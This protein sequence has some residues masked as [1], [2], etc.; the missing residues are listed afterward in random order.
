MPY[1]NSFHVRFDLAWKLAGKHECAIFTCATA[2]HFGP[3]V[4]TLKQLARSSFLAA[5][6]L[7][8][9]VVHK[10]ATQA[11]EWFY[12]GC[13]GCCWQMVGQPKKNK[14]KTATRYLCIAVALVPV[15][16]CFTVLKVFVNK[17]YSN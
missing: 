3:S 8:D 1:P 6:L 16:R 7:Q 9:I 15:L 4:L 10:W 14:V 11:L 13:V 2:A 12:S 17:K 5:A